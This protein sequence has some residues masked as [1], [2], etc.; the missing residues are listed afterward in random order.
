M[1]S[2]QQIVTIRRLGDRTASFRVGGQTFG[3]P[4]WTA[5]VYEARP[6]K[7]GIV[8]WRLVRSFGRDV[9]GSE[10]SFRFEREVQAAA[11]AMGLDYRYGVRHGQ[12]VR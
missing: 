3:R 9:S 12:R 6:R 4:L 5:A 2:A 8:T 1:T 7:D 10:P 11:A